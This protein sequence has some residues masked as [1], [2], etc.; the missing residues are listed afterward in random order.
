MSVGYPDVPIKNPRE[1]KFSTEPY[2]KALT[3]FIM[4]CAT[5]M[6]IAIQGDWGTGKTS[7]MYLV[8]EEL[9][10]QGMEEKKNLFWFNTWQYSQFGL[11]DQLVMV[12]LGKL[13]SEVDENGKGAV[14][15]K[16]ISALKSRQR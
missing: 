1:N 5:P 16:V 2:V 11:G 7:M 3:D 14:L 9:K 8:Q 10:K 4:S 13:A 12:M 6:T 15:D